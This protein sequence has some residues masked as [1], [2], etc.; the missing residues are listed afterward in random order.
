MPNF[1][2]YRGRK[3][4][5]DEMLFLFLSLNM[6]TWNS[7]SGGFAYIWQSKLV[8][9]I[10]I[11]TERTQIDFLNDVLVAVA[12]LDLKVPIESAQAL[13]NL[14]EVFKNLSGLVINSSKTEGMWIG[15]SR[16]KISKSF[17]IKWPDEPTKAVGVYYSYD[18]KLLHEKFFFERLDSVKKLINIWSSRGL[19]IYGKVTI[20]KS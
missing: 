11:K 15:S 2:F 18:I 9:I 1:T 7:A 19:S 10:A 16:D 13:F 5:N 20:I 4:I 6:L 8:V 14:L 12:S 17:G 3:Q